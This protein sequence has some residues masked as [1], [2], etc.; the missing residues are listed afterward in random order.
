MTRDMK[1]DPGVRA[2][3]RA[4]NGRNLMTNTRGVARWV[5][6]SGSPE[7]R[8]AVDWLRGVL[9]SYGFKTSI[10]EHDAYISLPGKASVDVPGKKL[11]LGPCQT[12]CFAVPTPEGGL[13]GD[14]VYAADDSPAGLARAGVRGKIVLLDGL[15][16]GERNQHAEAAGAIGQIYIQD[17]YIRMMPVSPLWGAPTTGTKQ[18]LPTTPSVSLTRAGGDKLKALLAE[19][20]V[21]V[22]I[23]A[24]VDTGWRKIPELV[25]DLPAADGSSKYVLFTSHQDS[26]YYGAM[27]NG[28]ANATVLE[29]ARIMAARRARLRRGLR[30]VFWSGHSHGRFAGSSWFVDHMFEDLYDNCVVHVNVDST[31]GK[32]A[33]V[34]DE[35]PVMAET[36][37]LGAE[38]IGLVTGEPF[39][40]KRIGRFGDQSFVGV[41][42]SSLFATFSEQ[43]INQ[44]G[45]NALRFAG[46]HGA[47]SGGLGWWWHN[48]HDTVDKVDR[49]F[50]VRDTRVYAAAMWRLL[51]LPVLPF[52][53]RATAV[54]FASVLTDYAAKAKGRLDLSRPIDL[55]NLLDARLHEL[56]ALAATRRS[57]RAAEAVNACLLALSRALVPV[58]YTVRGPYGQDL[59]L[60]LPPI[61]GLRDAARL[62]SL[63]EGN[64]DIYLLQTLMVREVNRVTFALRL[65]LQIAG[66]TVNQLKSR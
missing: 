3:V 61:P 10:I 5:R 46:A 7:E 8:Q 41:G 58:G 56:Y 26:W 53:F 11:D 48:E 18:Y 27:D 40:G 66:N 44:T 37:A 25:G 24:Q 34:V 23:Q 63:A 32:G 1:S 47:R 39:T 20:R 62:G 45:P 28:S 21:V 52:D 6:L 59:G 65:A 38:A 15:A 17:D 4:V 36:R 57:A 13:A 49:A 35:V 31:G 12:H 33:T 43:D 64:D 14:L 19:G 50:L 51:T 29:V 30:V 42:L 54:E 22:R 16:G 9:D 60:P 2:A 55:A